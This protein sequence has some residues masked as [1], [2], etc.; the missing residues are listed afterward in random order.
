[1]MDRQGMDGDPEVEQLLGRYASAVLTPDREAMTRVRAA[2]LQQAQVPA[3]RPRAEVAGIR[4]DTSR[5]VVP[6]RRRGLF[7]PWTSGRLGL[8]FGVALLTVVMLAGTVLAGARAGGPLY[9][10][11]LW[12][13]QI[14][15]PGQP[16]A[17]L[18]AEI[19]RAQTRL[20]EAT[21]AGAAGNDPGLQA[22]LDAYAR[23]VDQTLA[24]GATAVAGAERATLAFEHQQSVLEAIQ[25]R[26]AESDSPAADALDHALERSSRAIVRLGQA[27]NP[28]ARG[29]ADGVPRSEAGA[30]PAVGGRRPGGAGAGQG[31]A[32]GR[33][34]ETGA[35]RG[36]RAGSG[37]G[38]TSSG[39][40][41]AN[42]RPEAT[43]GSRDPRP[44]PPV[45]RPSPSPRPSEAG[46][47]GG[48][49]T[50]GEIRGSRGT[51]R[52]PAPSPR[53]T[54]SQGA[55]MSSNGPTGG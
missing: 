12:L 48:P 35:G 53:A 13:E 14:T 55:T 15:L 3:E 38:A 32:A 28:A 49:Q 34:R 6:V 22:A 26:L 42:A 45:G 43:A 30:G 11:R 46:R 40:P 37:V 27:G 18:E 33:G 31:P 41:S 16:D 36:A 5:E 17:R 1:M 24:E 9:T 51:R 44:S 2:V 54:P 47:P 4:R 8:A 23:I 20:A 25:E 39:K 19:A 10:A 50:S 52:S 29:P 21:E 7:P